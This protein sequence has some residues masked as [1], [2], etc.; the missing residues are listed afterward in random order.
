MV[1]RG[2]RA[3]AARNPLGADSVSTPGDGAKR[4]KPLGWVVAAAGTVLLGLLLW[5]VRDALVEWLLPRVE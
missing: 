4:V 3:R 5:G 1:S 2:G